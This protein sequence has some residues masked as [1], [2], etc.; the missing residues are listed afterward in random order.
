MR[1]KQY[2]LNIP[3]SKN[4]YSISITVYWKEHCDLCKRSIMMLDDSFCLLFHSVAEM[5][6]KM[7]ENFENR[8]IFNSFVDKNEIV[9]SDQTR[10]ISVTIVYFSQC[11][12]IGFAINSNRKI[13]LLLL[14]WFRIWSCCNFSKAIQ[15]SILN[16]SRVITVTL[17]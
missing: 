3:K 14:F 2:L 5:R 6:C 8:W 16:Q 7:E 13:F 4:D 12:R 11:S 9:V 1:L 15:A 10:T 17:F